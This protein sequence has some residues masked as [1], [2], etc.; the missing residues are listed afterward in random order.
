MQCLIYHDDACGLLSMYM[1]IKHV[2]VL[3]MYIL[4]VCDI[5]YDKLVDKGFTLALLLDWISYGCHFQMEFGSCCRFVSPEALKIEPVEGDS[6][7][8]FVF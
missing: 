6:S 1:Y 5:A 4:F 2:V 3:Y 8:S 7:V